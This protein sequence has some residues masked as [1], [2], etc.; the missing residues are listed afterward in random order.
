VGKTGE[1]LTANYAPGNKASAVDS[2]VEI[3]TISV[4]MV[5]LSVR[6][7]NRRILTSDNDRLTPFGRQ[8]ASACLLLLAAYLVSVQVPV[9]DGPG[10]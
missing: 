5:T 3:E 9:W 4:T 8:W 10:G 7:G 1:V 6:T 2:E